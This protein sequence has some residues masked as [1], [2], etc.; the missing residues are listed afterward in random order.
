M[1]GLAMQP[2]SLTVPESPQSQV[3]LKAEM[4]LRWMN[5]MSWM[6]SSRLFD[7]CWPAL[8]C[9]WLVGWC[10]KVLGNVLVKFS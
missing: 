3:S 9:F 10:N 8:I 7:L 5:F 1:V 4:G 2:W 6:V